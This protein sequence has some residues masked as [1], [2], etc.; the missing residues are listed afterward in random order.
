MESAWCPRLRASQFSESVPMFWRTHVSG[1]DDRV[2]VRIDDWKIVGDETLTQFQLYNVQVDPQETND[3]SGKMP[4]KTEEMKKS[5]L[6][7]WAGIESEG[8]RQWWE[9]ETQ[10]PKRGSKL[11]Y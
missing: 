3:L 5:L 4:D 2:A 7:V 8:P 1:P 6:E 10:R 11:N 9:K